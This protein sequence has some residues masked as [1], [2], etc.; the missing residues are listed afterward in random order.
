M[1]SPLIY[2]NGCSYSNS[3][4]YPDL[5]GKVHADYVGETLNGFVLNKSICGS[6]NRRII[7]TSLHDIIHQRQLNPKQKI[8]ALISLSFEIRSDLWVDDLIINQVDDI[9]PDYPEESQFV[10]HQFSA[11]TDWRERLL[12]G[13]PIYT[14]WP[15]RIQS[16]MLR[17][18]F[19][20]HLSRAKAFFFSSYAERINLL[21]DLLMFT[22]VCKQYNINYL[23]FQAPIAQQL[24]DEYLL[25]F[26][27]DQIAKDLRIFNLETFGF[28]NWA[29]EQKFI[30]LDMLDNPTIG[31]Y[32]SDAH[33]AFADQVLIP[34]LKETKQ[35]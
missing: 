5:N 3:S 21:T 4:Y 25:D 10:T 11:L 7:R 26:F 9:T 34:K 28:L 6:N 20:T 14:P 19:S 32:N 8:I 31:H 16:E 33:K 18:K 15:K 1:S 22:A 17:S 2:A 23:I 35:I 30:P 29:H 24:N 27:K 12:L 13:K